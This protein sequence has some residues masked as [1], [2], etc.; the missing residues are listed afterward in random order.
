MKKED[1]CEREGCPIDIGLLQSLKG[2]DAFR[3]VGSILSTLICAA[4]VGICGWLVGLQSQLVDVDR[5]NAAN[6]PRIVV[7][8]KEVTSLRSEVMAQSRASAAQQEYQSSTERRLASMEAKIDRLLERLS[9]APP[10]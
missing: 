5:S 9:S 2:L 10:K 7:L 1:A 3:R 8:E 4:I 6:A